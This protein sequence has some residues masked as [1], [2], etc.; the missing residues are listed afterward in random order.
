[1]DVSVE[2]STFNNCDITR[3]TLLCL[4]TQSFPADRFEVVIS[5]DGSTD[6]S[7]EMF[8]DL[9][10]TLPYALRVIR[11]DH[12]G[13]AHAHNCGIRAAQGNIVIMLAADIFAS[14]DLIT[15]HVRVHET[16][17]FPNVIVCGKLVQSCETPRTSFQRG[18]DV[19]IDKLFRT[20]KHDLRHG[21]FLVSNLSFK[22]D[23]MIEK[24]MFLDWPPAAQEDL[25]LGFRLR[26]Q[27]ARMIHSE[28]ALGYHF[29]PVTVLA[30]A[31]RAYTEGY[32][33]HYLEEK[34]PEEWVKLRAGTLGA[35]GNLRPFL[36]F[37]TRRLCRRLLVNAFT[38]ERIILPLIVASEKL[39][40]L[41]AVVPTLASKL[42]SFYFQL[43]RCDQ[44]RGRPF[45]PP[46][47]IRQVKAV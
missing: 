45:S 36:W 31:R 29:H 42:S 47:E 23:F 6:G 18:W 8:D 20:E 22:R 39:E 26:Q 3:K 4:A 13:P 27:G 34:V 43:G 14:R 35:R 19:L 7:L 38:I 10:P 28:E 32:N 30:V 46:R 2:I 37:K 16:N 5:D 9:A 25:E 33:W 41:V 21:G 15:E 40:P 12:K 17:P 11:N 44:L 1:M 24:G